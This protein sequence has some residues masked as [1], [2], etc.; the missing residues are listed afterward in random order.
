MTNV[1]YL[2]RTLKAYWKFSSPVVGC[3]QQ[4]GRQHLAR[5]DGWGRLVL[6]SWQ[7]GSARGDQPE[8]EHARADAEQN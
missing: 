6:A 3:P 8:G 5:R 7:R 2:V 4:F 1:P